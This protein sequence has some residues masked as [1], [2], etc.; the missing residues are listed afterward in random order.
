MGQRGWTW[1]RQR[2]CRRRFVERLM[3]VLE[4]PELIKDPCARLVV[5]STFN[6]ILPKHH[7]SLSK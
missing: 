5:F 4:A 6:V 3:V 2:A 7:I 1:E